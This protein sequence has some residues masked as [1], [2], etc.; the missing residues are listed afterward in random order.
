[1]SK[2]LDVAEQL[3]DKICKHPLFD[4][5]CVHVE[6]HDIRSKLTHSLNKSGI[7]VAIGLETGSNR[8]GDAEG[9]QIE[10][11]FIILI[12]GNESFLK[13]KDKP[14]VLEYAE[15][16]ISL[17]HDFIP[18]HESNC[19]GYFEFQT[20]KIRPNT[21]FTIYEVSLTVTIDLTL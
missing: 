7:G 16:A 17:A 4:E 3:K 11:R 2:I 20:I 19:Y 13:G 15:K 1:M 14:E 9:P 5:H 12:A 10:A 6:S 8:K 21:T 18:C